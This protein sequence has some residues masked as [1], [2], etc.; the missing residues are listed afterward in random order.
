MDSRLA[1][2]PAGPA[3]VRPR[4]MMF[5]ADGYTIGKDSLTDEIISRAGMENLSATL[6]IDNYGQVPLETVVTSPVD[7][8]ILSS[9]R[10]GPPAMATQVLRHPALEKMSDRMRIVVMPGRLWECAG[11]G[12]IDAITLLNTAAQ[13]VPRKDLRE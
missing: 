8:L 3:G 12:N 10:D 1:S 11:P 5:N 4:A 7:V 6:G 13:E 9:D 2:I